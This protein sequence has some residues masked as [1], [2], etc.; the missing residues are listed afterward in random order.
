MLPTI[1]LSKRYDLGHGAFGA[2]TKRSMRQSPAAQ[3]C[4]VRI[5]NTRSVFE[6]L[7]VAPIALQETTNVRGVKGNVQ[8]LLFTNSGN[9]D[10]NIGLVVKLCLGLEFPFSTKGNKCCRC[11]VLTINNETKS[12]VMAGN[13]REGDAA[14]LDGCAAV[15][16]KHTKHIVI[17]I[18]GVAHKRG[19]NMLR[20]QCS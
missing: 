2:L 19:R 9:I 14:S 7:R 12:R 15:V 4:Q 1:K 13:D 3:Q 8:R 6:L 20:L 10:G 5:C 17:G 18:R 11:S 16:H